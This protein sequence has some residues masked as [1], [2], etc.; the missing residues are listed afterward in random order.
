MDIWMWS[1]GCWTAKKL[2][3]IYRTGTGMVLNCRTTTTTTTTTR[4]RE[5]NG[6]AKK[7][8]FLNL[9]Y[10]FI[11]VFVMRVCVYCIKKKKK[12]KKKKKENEVI[13]KKKE[14][15]VIAWLRAKGM[16]VEKFGQKLLSNGYTSMQ[17]LMNITRQDLRDIGVKQV[18]IAELMRFLKQVFFFFFFWFW[19]K[20]IW[21][22]VVSF[23]FS[24]I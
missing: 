18:H 3:L 14:N 5:T 1:T 22:G 20:N 19:E 13:A 8:S 12:K 21:W 7:Y 9:F 23:F 15:E 24:L 2:Q 4:G 16:A 10:S 6:Y 17:L 11:S